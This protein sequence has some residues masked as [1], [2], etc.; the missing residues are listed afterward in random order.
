MKF[1]KIKEFKFSGIK[2]IEE[3]MTINFIDKQRTSTFEKDLDINLIKGIYGAN[4]S[5][6]TA[7]IE[8]MKLYNNV[9]EVDKYLNSSQGLIKSLLNKNKNEIKLEIIFS[10]IGNQKISQELKHEMTIKYNDE[11]NKFN[12]YQEKIFKN[13][14]MIIEIEDG[15]IIDLENEKNELYTETL[16][17]LKDSTISSLIYTD[18]DKYTNIK[19][20]KDIEKIEVVEDVLNCFAKIKVLGEQKDDHTHEIFNQ[21]SEKAIERNTKMFENRHRVNIYSNELRINK[22]KVEESKKYINNK[23]RSITGFLKIFKPDINR[24]KLEYTEEENSVRLK[25]KVEYVNRNSID[26]EYESVGIKKLIQVYEMIDLIVNHD[27]IFFIDE[28]DAHLHDV[29]INKILE[30]IM[31]KENGQLVFVTHNVSIMDNIKKKKNSINIIDLEQKIHTWKNNGNY[32]PTS[33]YRKGYLTE[34]FGYDE[35]DFEEI[36]IAGDNDEE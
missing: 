10:Y 16:N 36:F 21:M 26:M 23:Y 12:I 3:K 14:K 13:N 6:K 8:A 29:A 34:D 11:N 4:G 25:C 19:E 27:C 28:L 2:N 35:F 1:I 32:S 9:M 20:K 7:V 17:L 31:D 24:I 33:L 5:G 22:E 15:K 30:Y 18:T